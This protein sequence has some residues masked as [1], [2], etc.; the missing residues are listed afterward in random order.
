[1]VVVL[2]PTEKEKLELEEEERMHFSGLIGLQ[3]EVMPYINSCLCFAT[4]PTNVTCLHISLRTAGQPNGL[5]PFAV[6]RRAG[7]NYS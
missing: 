6:S 2:P 5:I 1:M 7:S 4:P 3:L